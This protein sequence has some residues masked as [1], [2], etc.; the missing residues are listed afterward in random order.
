MTKA[1]LVW[2]ALVGIASFR[3]VWRYFHDF[4]GFIARFCLNPYSTEVVLIEGFREEFLDVL[5]EGIGGY[6]PVLGLAV[7][8]DIAH[9]ATDEVGLEAGLPK[10]LRNYRHLFRNR[11]VHRFDSIMRLRVLAVCG[12]VLPRSPCG[13]TDITTVFGTVILGSIPGGGTLRVEVEV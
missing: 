7:E 12:V 9:A 1:D 5:G 6:V 3:T 8:E 2:A 4:R 13:E 10:A 11:E